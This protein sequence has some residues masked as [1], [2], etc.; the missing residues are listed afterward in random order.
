MN[1][2]NQDRNLVIWVPAPHEI[3]AEMLALARVSPGDVVCDLGCGDGRILISAV[4]DFG[5]SRAIGYELSQEL[6]KTSRKMIRHLALQDRIGIINQDLREADLAGASVVTLYLTTQANRMLRDMLERTLK[7]GTRV[8]TY[9]FP[10]SGWQPAREV[11]LESRSF[12]E[13]RF[14]GK[15]YLYLIPQA[16]SDTG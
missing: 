1:E 2:V 12:K 7:P 14:V 5:A 8:V 10:V 6:C 15:L 4:K 16:Y 11:D 13:G 3:V 9:L